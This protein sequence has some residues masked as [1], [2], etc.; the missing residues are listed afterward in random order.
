MTSVFPRVGRWHRGYHVTQVDDFFS[1]A[2]TAY[3][4]DE[5][6]DEAVRNAAFDMVVDGYQTAVVDAALDR[7]EAAVVRRK[8]ASH[9]AVASE[10]SWMEHAVQ[11]A[12]T[13]YPRLQRPVGERFAPA[14]GVGYAKAD[15]DALCERLIGY[16]ESGSGVSAHDIRSATFD[17]ARAENA[18]EEAVVDAFLDRAV[19]VLLAVE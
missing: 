11:R 8:R 13:L 6:E 7:L 2:R 4:R 18:Y 3:E 16:F 1:S 10:D 14:H 9:V 12:T 17:L 19:E 15:V 5:I